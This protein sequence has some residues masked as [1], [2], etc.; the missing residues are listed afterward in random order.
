MTFTRSHRIHPLTLPTEPYLPNS[1]PQHPPIYSSIQEHAHPPFHSHVHTHTHSL[2]FQSQPTRASPRQPT[3]ILTTQI[4][5]P[6]HLSVAAHL[7]LHLPG[8]SLTHTYT[9]ILTHPPPSHSPSG[10]PPSSD[11]RHR[12]PFHPAVVQDTHRQRDMH[13]YMHSIK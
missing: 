5:P 9:H 12:R 2:T 1:R 13:I 4:H 7:V 10:T 11:G 6:S 3:H 8:H